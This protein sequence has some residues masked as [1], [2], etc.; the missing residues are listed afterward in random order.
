MEGRSERQLYFEG[1]RAALCGLHAVNTLL[2]GPA[3]TEQQLGEVARELDEAERKVM[4]ESGVDSA[5]YLRFMGEQSGNV[6][7]SGDF[8][9]QVLERCLMWHGLAP[10]SVESPEGVGALHAPLQEYAFIAN[11]AQ[12]WFTIRRLELRMPGG[13]YNFNSVLPAPAPVSDLYLENFLAQLRAEGFTVFAIR[14]AQAGGAWPDTSHL[15]LRPSTTGEWLTKE[16]C[17]SRTKAAERARTVGRGNAA[18]NG[19][20][21]SAGAGGTL[22]LR[23]PGP[24]RA[25]GGDDEDPELA[26]ALAAS[27]ADRRG[28]GAPAAPPSGGEDAELARAIAASLAEARPAA[29]AELVP[30]EPAPG[31]PGALEVALRLPTGGRLVRRFDGS[32]TVGGVLA[33]VGSQGVDVQGMVLAT[34]F[35]RATLDDRSRTLAAL[36]VADKSVLSVERAR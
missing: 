2:Q 22:Q 35:P 31:A 3:A 17:V 20:L 21:Q 12:H 28:G 24:P 23:A 25:L 6:S 29:P 27:L 19:I 7:A 26:A 18:V 30:A 1:Q 9:I 36:G 10:V 15:Y 16:Q 11:L 4:A 8:S 5:D 13:W 33:F 32:A 14:P 34:A